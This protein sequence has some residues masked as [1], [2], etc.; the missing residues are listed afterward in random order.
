MGCRV[1]LH[2]RRQAQKSLRTARV[3]STPLTTPVEQFTIT[4]MQM[5]GMAHLTLSWRR[6]GR[7][8]GPFRALS[9]ASS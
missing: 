5:G 6:P 7:G 8:H 2:R 1:H 3:K 9:R 4:A